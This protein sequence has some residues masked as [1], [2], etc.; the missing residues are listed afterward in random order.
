[1]ITGDSSLRSD[2]NLETLH[3]HIFPLVP[4]IQ[5]QGILEAASIY[6]LAVTSV[7]Q[8]EDSF[9]ASYSDSRTFA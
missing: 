1:M 4:G 6:A 2:V 7:C 8:E 9:H 5:D 3:L